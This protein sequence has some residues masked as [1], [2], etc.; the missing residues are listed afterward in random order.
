MVGLYISHACY[1]CLLLIGPELLLVKT[2]LQDMMLN[3]MLHEM[4]PKSITDALL[5]KYSS[6]LLFL[7]NQC[8]NLVVHHYHTGNKRGAP[9]KLAVHCLMYIIIA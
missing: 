4:G 9:F 3:A 5:L 2:N 7:N 6:A 8:V 1:T